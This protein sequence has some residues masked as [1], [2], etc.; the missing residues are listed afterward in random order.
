MIPVPEQE[1]VSY[2]ALVKLVI[3]IF[4]IVGAT[5]TFFW[6]VI[7]PIQGIQVQLAQIQTTLNGNTAKMDDFQARLTKLES[8]MD[9]IK[10][11]LTN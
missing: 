5:A 11:Q 7:I 1:N 3:Y 10:E 2:Q 9:R 8:Q 6:Y 4:S